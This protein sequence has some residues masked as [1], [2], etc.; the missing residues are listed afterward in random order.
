MRWINDRVSAR[1]L[2]TIYVNQFQLE[3]AVDIG[4]IL[5]CRIQTN[6]FGK[7]TDLL[8]HSIQAGA[9]LAET[10]IKQGNRVGLL[11]YGGSRNWVFPGYGKRQR[12]KILQVLATVRLHDHFVVQELSK[13]P[14]RLFPARSQLVFISSLVRKDL[15]PLLAL[16]AHGYK[17]LVI[18]PDPIDLERK[19][20]TDI[21]VVSQAVRIARVER[22]FVLRQMRRAGVRVFEW[23]V[24]QPFHLAARFALARYTNWGQPLGGRHG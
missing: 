23:Q 1:H 13:L 9:T 8:E 16:R 2:E 12:E 17:V 7:N 18:T 24:D 15:T 11:I 22:N 20:L 6:S 14:T 10:F 5:D 19:S 21:P 3:R 4:L